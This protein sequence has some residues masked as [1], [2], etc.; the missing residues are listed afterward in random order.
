MTPIMLFAPLFSLNVYLFVYR[1]S[2]DAISLYVQSIAFMIPISYTDGDMELNEIEAFIA[3]Q[4][5]GNFTR[6]ANALYISQPAISRRIELLERE[7]GAP[8]FERL[9]MGVRLTEAG[10][11]FLPHAQQVL[12]ALHDGAVAVH[13]LEED[14]PGQAHGSIT[15]AL[16][17]TLAGTHLTGQLQAFRQTYP[18]VRLLLRTARSDEVSELV[19]QGEALLGLRYFNDP[20]AGICSQPVIEEPLQV[21]SALQS[22][23]IAG[24]PTE[25]AALAGIPWIGFPTGTR[26][27]GEPFAHILT[28]QLLRTGLDGAEMIEIDSL[29]AQKRLIEADFGVGLLPASSIEEEVRL[30]TMRVL[31]VDALTTT[32]PVVAIYR[33]QGYLS[34]AA[35]LLLEMLTHQR[36]GM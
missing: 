31:P 19:Q 3:I 5:I 22:R 36:E 29:P 24:T 23:L 28:R 35:R 25:P 13:A 16:V 18:L 11:A 33:R 12:A 10:R 26:S 7:L 8:L 20:R 34:R 4:R 21:V 15:L 9:P 14:V 32:V 27:S 6:A 30:G 17:G 2:I 1:N